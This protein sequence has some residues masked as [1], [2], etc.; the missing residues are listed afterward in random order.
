MIRLTRPPCPN[1][2]ALRADYRHP[3]NK[4][5]L[6]AA[7]FDKC[8]YCESKVSHSYFGDIEHIRPRDRFPALEFNW[9]NLGFVCAKCNN[10]KLHQWHDE[11]PYV[12]PYDEDP[13]AH[14]AAVGA[15]VLHRAGSERGEVTWR[16][17]CLNRP[18]LLERRGERIEA[19]HALIDKVNRTA[20]PQLRAALN[21]ELDREVQNHTAYSFVA[22][23]AL[24][25][26]R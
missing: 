3:V 26:L 22:K 21:G 11:T 8:M 15:L 4:A 23:A 2:I 14:L 24:A 18:E 12:N 25:A 5:A 7:S 16:D 6:R 10:A 13:S 20:D 17:I 1:P 19:L 9:D